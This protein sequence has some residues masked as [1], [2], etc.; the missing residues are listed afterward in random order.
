MT[1]NGT[2]G[3]ENSVSPKKFDLSVT[4]LNYMP[5]EIFEGDQVEVTAIIKNIGTSISNDFTV[6]LFLDINSYQ[7]KSV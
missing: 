4:N 5:T 3:N 1:I 2:P 6:L 7:D